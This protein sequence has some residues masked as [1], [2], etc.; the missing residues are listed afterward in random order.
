MTTCKLPFLVDPDSRLVPNEQVALKVF[1]Q[2][3]KKLNDSPEDKAMVIESQQK[4]QDLGFVDYVSNLTEEEKLLILDSDVKYFIPWR[5]V[6][7]EGSVTTG[8][9]MVFDGTQ[10]TKEGC[11]LNS[12]LPKGVNGMNKLN[13][14]MIRW[15]TWKHAFHTDI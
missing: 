2:Q 7:N 4:L 15:S 11:S 1:R 10:S 9:R 5:A 3:V 12:L 6:W 13:E 8:C 14:I